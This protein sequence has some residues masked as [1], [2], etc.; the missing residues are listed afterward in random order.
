MR[1][2]HIYLTSKKGSALI[3]IIL[4]IS[5]IISLGI[6]IYHKNTLEQERI[7]YQAKIDKLKYNVQLLKI[8]KNNLQTD[9]DKLLLEQSLKKKEEE[10]LFQTA[11][12]DSILDKPQ[13][14]SKP[15]VDVNQL[16]G[17]D[18]LSLLQANIKIS[19]ELQRAKIKIEEIN[20]VK[21]NLEKQ[22]KILHEKYY[23][24][25]NN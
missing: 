20:L 2:L 23:T 17:T 19:D 1:K 21:A 7:L 16:G 18:M 12:P 15:P 3:V 4:F 25:K 24:N 5:I 13:N 9:I 22:I 6:Y 8:E 10:A 11:T 14:I